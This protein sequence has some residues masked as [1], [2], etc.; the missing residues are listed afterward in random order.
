MGKKNEIKLVKGEDG[1]YSS[2]EH[3]SP[4]KEKPKKT[5]KN[6]EEF[7]EGMD[8]GLDFL[9]GISPRIERLFKLRR[10]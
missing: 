2:E 8:A 3:R 6:M 10:S 9:E 4:H 1:V 5:Y 7:F